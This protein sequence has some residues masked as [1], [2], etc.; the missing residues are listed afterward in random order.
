M[1]SFH[2]RQQYLHFFIFSELCKKLGASVFFLL[3]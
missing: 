1:Q 3:E 2:E